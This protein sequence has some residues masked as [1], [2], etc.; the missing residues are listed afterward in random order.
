M[1]TCTKCHESK[2]L[3]E[4]NREAKGK[5]GRKAACRPCDRRRRADCA[6]RNAARAELPPVPAEKRCY[7]C[8]ET[9][10]GAEFNRD[11]ARKDGLRSVCRPCQNHRRTE[12]ARG[13]PEQQRASNRRRRARLA[14]VNSE[15]Y[16]LLALEIFGAWPGRCSHCRRP[17]D[18][19]AHWPESPLARTVDHVLP[20]SLGGDDIEANVILA[21]GECNVSRGNR[22]D[23]TPERI[24]G[25]DGEVV[26]ESL[27]LRPAS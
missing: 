8:K 24:Y 13:H 19:D 10:P 1:K 12:H 21:C 17:F 4:F 14:S 2:S 15:P 6:R 11:R 9:K 5:E 3:D 22:V 27:R 16:D 25:D 20:I 23:W 7:D 18:Y 26:A